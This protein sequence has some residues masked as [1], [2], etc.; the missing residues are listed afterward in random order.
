MRLM[1][2]PLVCRPAMRCRG[3]TGRLLL[4]L[5]GFL[6]LRGR[7]RVMAPRG[8]SAEGVF[9]ESLGREIRPS[10]AT[11]TLPQFLRPSGFRLA[12]A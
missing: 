7:A 3:G 6:W 4:S 8:I 5:C 11:L 12:G 1:E 9:L 10:L 2:A